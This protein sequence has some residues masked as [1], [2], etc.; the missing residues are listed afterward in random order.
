MRHV[1]QW[2][3]ACP[4]TEVSSGGPAS[5]IFPCEFSTQSDHF[6]VKICQR[7]FLEVLTASPGLKDKEPLHRTRRFA[8]SGS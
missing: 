6:K 3:G 1:C 4:G 2:P 8:R 7:L 5:L